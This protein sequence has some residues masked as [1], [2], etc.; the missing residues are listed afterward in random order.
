MK[1]TVSAPQPVQL[2][3]KAVRIQGKPEILLC[4]SLF[5]FRIPRGHWR[6][7]M[8]QLRAYGYNCIDVYFPWNWH[9]IREGVWEM[10]GEKDVAAFLQTAAEVGLWVVAR[11]GPYICSEW[12][13]GGLPAY[14]HTKEGMVIRDNNQ[15]FLN[16]VT[17]WFD[18]VMPILAR[19]QIGEEGT[20][21]CVQLDNELDF[22][23]CRDPKGYISALRDMA[24]ARGIKVPLIACAGQGGLVEAS[25]IADGVMPTCNFY[26]YD[27][28]PN[29][30]EKVLT[31]RRR[32][33]ELGYPL[34][35]TETNRSHFLLR[36]LLSCGAK[37]LGPYLQVSGTDFGFTNATNNWGQPLAFLASDYDFGGMISPEGHVRPEAYEGLLLSRLIRTYGAALAEAELEASE[38]QAGK[39]A[40]IVETGQASVQALELAGGGLILFI[41]NLGH[42]AAV[43]RFAAEE[44]APMREPLMQLELKPWRSMAL[45]FGVPLRHW[46]IEGTLL[47]ST[48]ELF[49]HREGAGGATLAF[50]AEHGAEIALQLPGARV[51]THTDLAVTEEDG[52]MILRCS[53]GATGVCEL[54]LADG[55]LLRLIVMRRADAL[56]VDDIDDRGVIRLREKQEPAREPVELPIAWSIFPH[57]GDEPPGVSWTRIDGEL[58]YLETYGIYRGLTWLEA[59]VDAPGG[60]T[61]Q[62]ILVRQGSDIISVYAG[63][64]YVATVVPG[65][66][67]CY[68]PAPAD[69]AAGRLAARLEIWG[70]SNFDDVRLPALRLKALRGMR[71]LVSVTRVIELSQN[72]RVKLAE[73]R[74][75]LQELAERAED[76]R[77]WPIVAYGGWLSPDIPQYACYRRSF[78]LS[79][80]ADAWTMH[81]SGLQAVARVYING[82]DAGPVY[83]SDPF[84]DITP[85]VEPGSRVEVT[86]L[87]EKQPVQAAGRVRVYEGT[88]ARHWR[89]ANREQDE[90]WAYASALRTEKAAAAELPLALMGG[91]TAWLAT[92]LRD[93]NSGRGWRVRVQG[94]NLKLTVLFHGQIVGRLWLKGSKARPAFTGG[95]QDS[96]YLPGPWFRDGAIRLAILLEALDGEE[97]SRLEAL[98]FVPV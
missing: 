9:E 69:S 54:A 81:F 24:I 77:A 17:H 48:A 35:V 30:E 55:R 62:G 7:R 52:G 56:L 22:Y 32:L 4:A 82:V 20:I 85:H 53:A 6:D 80:E 51:L 1:S 2:S 72:W 84:V 34:L 38:Q 63:R 36:R 98:A 45:P 40:A 15:P 83:P 46:G 19:Y 31:Y 73:N 87:L 60:I 94:A 29:F 21:I 43:I 71:S 64:E 74:A 76:D 89:L 96:F 33:A 68:I 13:G 41:S 90:L 10:D 75:A 47:C 66:S 3:P 59:S 88:A 95:L 86:V 92:E 26:P 5:Y 58:D 50:H 12:D 61:R 16:A 18:Q 42:G 39:I 65:G 79:H 67:S 49:L 97:P 70:H 78:E 93:S 8:L 91:E 28:D 23:G 57:P 44:G 37:L 27:R 11:P 14:L 25:G